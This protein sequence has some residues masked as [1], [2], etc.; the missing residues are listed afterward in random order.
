MTGRDVRLLCILVPVST[1]VLLQALAAR[2]GTA[3]A[4]ASEAPALCAYVTHPLMDGVS[5]IDVHRRA[6]VGTIPLSDPID[7]ALRPDGRRAYVTR[8]ADAGPNG[9]V[10]VIDTQSGTVGAVLPITRGEPNGIKVSPDGTFGLVT[11]S[12]DANLLVRLDTATGTL[13]DLLPLDGPPPR[14]YELA[15]SVAI[16]PD[17]GLAYAA[18]HDVRGV[19]GHQILAVD[20]ASGLAVTSLAL[21]TQPRQ[22]AFAPDGARAYATLSGPTSDDPS[23]LLVIDTA[24]HTSTPLVQ[25][26][27]G[28]QFVAPSPDGTTLYVSHPIHDRVSVIDVASNALRNEIDSASFPYA[29]AFA[30][31][32]SVL[33]VTNIASRSVT[34][35]DPAAEAVVA[36]ITVP[37]E[38]QGLAV[39]FV[40]GGCVAPP[41]PPTATPSPSA[42]PTPT[43]PPPCGGDCDGDGAVTI[44]ELLRAVAIAIGRMTIDRCPAANLDGSGTVTVDDIVGATRN[45]LS[46]CA[47]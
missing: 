14:R 5:V 6:W 40:P 32:G 22:I 17:S 36:T 29:L 42:T 2:A 27:Y 34:V 23:S 37:F 46:G 47:A 15:F 26:P 25:F 9:S 3:E 8:L 45:A 10:A 44:A 11:L 31:D 33:L 35:I 43:A 4:Q 39:G 19:L 1:C 24:T 13:T 7:V 38:P 18:I 16:S 30:P 41:L 28:A 12:S 20:P 21:P